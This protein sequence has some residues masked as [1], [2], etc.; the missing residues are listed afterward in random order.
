MDE[1]SS[2]EFGNGPSFP[3]RP[4]KAEEKRIAKR[5]ATAIGK[6]STV[7]HEFE[8]GDIIVIVGSY[9]YM[10]VTCRAGLLKAP[11]RSTP[12]SIQAF[13]RK[14]PRLPE[15]VLWEQYGKTIAELMTAPARAS[16]MMRAMT[17]RIERTLSGTGMELLRYHPT[18]VGKESISVAATIRMVDANLDDCEAVFH[19][20]HGASKYTMRNFQALNREANAQAARIGRRQDGHVTDAVMHAALSTMTT[21]EQRKLETFIREQAGRDR[22]YVDEYRNKELADR[23]LRVPEAIETLK[24]KDGII[25]G[26][27]R[28]SANAT[29]NRNRFLI[30]GHLPQSYVQK[31]AGMKLGDIVQHPWVPE[32]IIVEECKTHNANRTAIRI[33]VPQVHFPSG[34]P[35]PDKG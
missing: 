23:G 3:E 1:T 32:D 29:F 27:V 2:L 16:Q 20:E 7:S 11:F 28:I 17:D 13:Q 8:N 6:R 22:G 12:L 18:E 5:I 31:A 35:F 4:M 24:V 21:R 30:S 25:S 14:A 33:S 19:I 9:G 34:I 15:Q 26:R 10:D